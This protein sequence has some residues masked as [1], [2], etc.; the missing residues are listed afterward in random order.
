M[1]IRIGKIEDRDIEKAREFCLGIF[2]E[3]GWDKSFTY[4]FD[5]LKEF[6]GG[7]KEVFFLAKLTLLAGGQE[8]KIVAC[9][10]LKELSKDQGLVK[11]FYVVKELRGKG[12][13]EK[14]LEKIKDFAKEKDYKIIVLD[15]FKGNERAK[16][17]FQKQGFEV[18]IPS[19][20]EKWSESQHP[21]IFEFRKLKL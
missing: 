7:A 17:F 1:A 14:M 19:P 11:R 6:F 2:E 20:A 4:G 15:I 5:N 10:G 8:E 16:R 9:G 18:F 3:M 13:A 21:E 12:L